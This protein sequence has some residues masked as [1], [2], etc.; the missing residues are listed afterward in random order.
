MKEVAQKIKMTEC[1][2]KNSS[3]SFLC[4]NSEKEEN[5]C[6]VLAI[7]LKCNTLLNYR[8]SEAWR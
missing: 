3:I 6:S 5:C 1:Q 7:A 8:D 4:V 2:E